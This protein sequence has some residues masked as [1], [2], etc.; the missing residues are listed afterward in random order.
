MKLWLL[1]LSIEKW[2]IGGYSLGG[3]IA[4]DYALNHQDKINGVIYWA[5]Y[6]NKSL[7]DTTLKALCLHGTEDGFSTIAKIEEEKNIFST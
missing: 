3:A 4:S 5:A 2:A 1:I 6:P 7:G